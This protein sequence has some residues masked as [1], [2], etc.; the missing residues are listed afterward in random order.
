[1]AGPPIVVIGLGATG[2][3]ALCQLAQRGVPAIGIGQFELGHDRGSSH[4]AT[5]I[6]RRTH[7]ENPSYVPLLD[8]AYALWRDIE[9]RAKCRLL[10]FTGIAEIGPAE[11]QLLR[12]TLAAARRMACRTRCWVRTEGVMIFAIEF[13]RIRASDNARATLDRVAHIAS[14]LE[15][16]KVKAKS[17]FETLDLA[18]KP[19]GLRIL[20]A[21]GRELF[22]WTPGCDDS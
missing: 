6:I 3:A 19:D 21:D 20:R 8:R 12:G 1:M 18:Q 5:R 7:F 11:G 10:L 17:L 2:S 22:F 14:D 9:R 15:G 16:A 13:F 4:G